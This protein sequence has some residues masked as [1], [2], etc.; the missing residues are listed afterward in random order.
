[1]DTGAKPP[2][3]TDGDDKVRIATVATREPRSMAP[4]ASF[5]SLACQRCGSLLDAPRV[6]PQT[7]KPGRKCGDCGRWQ[8]GPSPFRRWHGLL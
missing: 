8:D 3:N 2:D 7:G 5:S 6:D 1:M 4:A